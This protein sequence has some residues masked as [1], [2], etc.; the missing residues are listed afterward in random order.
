MYRYECRAARACLVL[1]LYMLHK[2]SQP[3]ISFTITLLLYSLWHK[4]SFTFS[5]HSK[6]H[7]SI[8]PCHPAACLQHCSHTV[9]FRLKPKVHLSSVYFF[10][11]NHKH[12]VGLWFGDRPSG[13]GSGKSSWQTDENLINYLLLKKAVRREKQF[14]WRGKRNVFFAYFLFQESKL[15]L[16]RAR[17]HPFPFRT[18]KLSSLLP[19]IL[20][21][22]RTGKIGSANTKVRS[23]RLGPFLCLLSS[24]GRACGC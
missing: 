14:S 20:V 1:I 7:S 5:W 19:K 24:V 6:I 9:R 11:P 16:I 10:L 4:F 8:A 22:R 21:W 2:N 18:R 15:V 13:G 12:F 3:I 17:V 23:N